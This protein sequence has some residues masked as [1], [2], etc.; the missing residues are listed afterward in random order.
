MT[1]YELTRFEAN[2]A[3]KQKAGTY[4]ADV[5]ALQLTSGRTDHRQNPKYKAAEDVYY[6]LT[7]AC[8]AEE[9]QRWAQY[10]TANALA[11]GIQTRDMDWV[12]LFLAAYDLSKHFDK[13]SA[14]YIA[15]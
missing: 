3:C 6:D 8:T 1:A 4:C 7:G 11:Y 14:L 10:W 15:Y 12:Y 9:A 5:V 13:H 2:Y